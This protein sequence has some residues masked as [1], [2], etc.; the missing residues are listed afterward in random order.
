M[1]LRQAVQLAVTF[2]SGYIAGVFCTLVSHPFD[3]VV[4]KLNSDVGSS[5]WQTFKSLG[6]SGMW[7]GLDPRIAMVGTLTA[8]QWFVYDTYKIYMR[9]FRPPPPIIPESFRKKQEI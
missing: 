4:S 5:P 7:K 2:T 9:I 8:A 1:S 3:T 6:F